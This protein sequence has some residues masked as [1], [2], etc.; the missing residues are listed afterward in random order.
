MTGSAAPA[1]TYNNTFIRVP[2]A[3]RVSL[4]C[5]NFQRTNVAGSENSK[6]IAKWSSCRKR[7]SERRGIEARAA[8]Y[9]NNSR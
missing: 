7:K 9:F 8:V 3:E 5:I 1:T 2:Q 4:K 6:E